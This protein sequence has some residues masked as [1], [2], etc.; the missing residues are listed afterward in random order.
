MSARGHLAWLLVNVL[1][2][3]S[4]SETL[5]QPPAGDVGAAA[6]SSDGGDQST[7]G[8]GGTGQGAT[9]GSAAGGVGAGAGASA[10]A[11]VDA[12]AGAG[13]GGEVEITSWPG[14]GDVTTVAATGL[15]RGNVSGLTYQPAADQT[16]AVLWATANIP[17]NLYRL[18]PDAA[19]FASDGDNG[20]SEGKLLHFP[21]GQGA[22]DA[23]SVTLAESPADGVYVASEHDNDAASTSR[24]SI[25]RYDVNE[26]GTS[27]SATHEWNLTAVLPTVGANLG[28][29]A[30]TW[31]PDDYLTARA[32]FDESTQRIYDASSYPA[33][34]AGV[35][36]VG[37][38]GT[39][40]IHGVVLDHTSD[41][42]QLVATISS[43][44]SGVMSLEY[45][46]DS[47]YL[48]F[49]C[50]YACDNRSGVLSVDTTPG[51]ATIGRF[52]VRRVFQPPAGLPSTD[53]EGIAIAPDA[54]CEGGLKPFFWADDAALDGFALRQGRIPCGP[55]L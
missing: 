36:F 16:S 44:L 41:S 34:G 13:P 2:C 38:E 21:D 37:V 3:G 46:R 51:S 1:A 47:G 11:S 22:A 17:G 18:L 42:L 24:L 7:A 27:L 48:W 26:P 31:V 8:S 6:R 4:Q 53:N 30:I 25:L 39:G 55:F 45:D 28:I 43:P 14:P 54:A 5:L 12:G 19:G 9:A 49:A 23:E 50:D 52:T 40:K 33:H 20:W 35:F 15:I 10:G 29:E 32:F